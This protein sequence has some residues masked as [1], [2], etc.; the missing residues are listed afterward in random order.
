MCSSD[1][2]FYE[3][4]EFQLED[5]QCKGTYIKKEVYITDAI[6]LMNE[7]LLKEVVGRMMM[8]QNWFKETKYM[9]SPVTKAHHVTNANC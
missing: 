4:V 3:T 2:I 5:P 9:L 6:H 8:P 7:N 1:Q